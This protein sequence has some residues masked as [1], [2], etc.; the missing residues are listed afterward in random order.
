MIVFEH[1]WDLASIPEGSIATLVNRFAST[2]LE[3]GR[4]DDGEEVDAMKRITREML[5]ASFNTIRL[6]IQESILK[7]KIKNIH[8]EKIAQES[9][10][11]KIIP[12]I[13]YPIVTGLICLQCDGIEIFDT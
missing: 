5:Y 13:A 9:A 11:F 7:R 1:F 4:L 8:I 2:Y 6:K 3:D 12:K 10:F